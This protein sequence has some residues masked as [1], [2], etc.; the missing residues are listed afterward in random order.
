[1]RL[2]PQRVPEGVKSFPHLCI[3]VCGGPARQ[4]DTQ[5]VAR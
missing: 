2:L 5:G 3:L 1:M 4:F